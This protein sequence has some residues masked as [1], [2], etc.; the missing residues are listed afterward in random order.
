MTH[1]AWASIV[2]DRI[3]TIGLHRPEI[4][5]ESLLEAERR[6]FREQCE[7]D[8]GVFRGEE[9]A[10]EVAL[11]KNLGWI[12]PQARAVPQKT[13]DPRQLLERLPG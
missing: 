4:I 12:F 7:I 6:H 8:A 3:E 2:S 9:P 10:G 13:R 1:R 11:G 5:I